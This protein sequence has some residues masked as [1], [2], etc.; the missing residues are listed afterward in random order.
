MTEATAAVDRNALR[1]D[2]EAVRTEYL[3]LLDS[4]SADDWK[5]KSA[6]LA[7]TVGTLMWHMGRG[8]EFLSQAVAFCRKGKAPNPPQFLVNPVNSLLNRFGSRGATPEAARAKYEGGHTALLSL[9]D[10]VQDGEWAKGAKIYGSDYTIE[11]VFRTA[12]SHW[13]EHKADILKGLGRA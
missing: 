13:D 11:S 3:A 1:T 5:A 7:W 4:L 6:N 12:R 10:S 2:I 8:T 9:L